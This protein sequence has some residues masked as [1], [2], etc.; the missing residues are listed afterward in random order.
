MRYRF[1]T[2]TPEGNREGSVSFERSAGEVADA[3]VVRVGNSE[4]MANGTVV[5][6]PS[7]VNPY[8]P[9]RAAVLNQEG[10]R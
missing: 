4:L 1:A 8:D 9:V 2:T 7:T 6:T 3:D 10:I 5:P